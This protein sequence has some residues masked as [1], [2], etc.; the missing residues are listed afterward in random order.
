MADT[1]GWENAGFYSRCNWGHDRSTKHYDLVETEFQFCLSD[2]PVCHSITY[3]PV[4]TG[5]SGHK[6]KNQIMGTSIV[7][8]NERVIIRVERK[9]RMDT[10][11]PLQ[12]CHRRELGIRPPLS[13]YE[14]G[15]R[16]L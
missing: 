8:V 5:L 16:L 11:K 14:C 1:P 15:P 10:F 6:Q 12:S 3:N 9:L 4:K 7:I 13:Y 2:L